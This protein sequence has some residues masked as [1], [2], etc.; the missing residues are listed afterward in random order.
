MKDKEHNTER[1]WFDVETTGL[2]YYESEIVSLA[3][4]IEKNGKI[5]KDGILYARPD[6]FTKISPDALKVNG[7][8]I[9]QLKSF[10][11]QKELLESIKKILDENYSIRRKVERPTPAGYNSAGCDVI[12]LQQLFLKH[13]TKD[14]E[15]FDYFP[16]VKID[17]FVMV[18][19]I[20]EIVGVKF[21]SHRLEDLCKVFKIPH[22]P[23]DALSDIRA[24]YELYK[25]FMNRLRKGVVQ[26]N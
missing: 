16:S 5:V 12:F 20:E 21:A 26:K 11:S 15:F 14:Y 22:D 25:I 9:E 2:N 1:F 23:H 18:P 8:T 7:F 13:G 4:L 24:T 3:Y 6:D 10:P 19:M 17:V